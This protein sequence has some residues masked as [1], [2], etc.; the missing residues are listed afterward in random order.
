M[1]FNIV[2]LMQIWSEINLLSMERFLEDE[3]W[4]IFWLGEPVKTVSINFDVVK[5]LIKLNNA[6]SKLLKVIA[7]KITTATSKMSTI[8]LV[9]ILNLLENI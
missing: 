8:V 3:I 1:P 4:T 7:T 9:F 2:P 5:I 6:N